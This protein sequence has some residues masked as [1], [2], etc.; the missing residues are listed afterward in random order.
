MKPTDA[1]QQDIDRLK[2]YYSSD[3]QLHCQSKEL[4]LAKSENLHFNDKVNIRF[5]FSLTFV[6]TAIKSN[7][8]LEKTKCASFTFRFI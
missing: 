6:Q 2:K 8:G 1:G 7:E 4:F 5:F 3:Q